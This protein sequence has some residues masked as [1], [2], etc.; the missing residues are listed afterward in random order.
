[1]YKLSKK[2]L[3]KLDG[4]DGDLVRVV[5]RAIQITEVDFS[6]LEGLRTKDRQKELFESGASRTM[7]SRHIIGEAVDLGAYISGGISWDWKYYEQIAKAMK[8]AADELGVIITWGG[9]WATFR[10][11]VHFQV[12]H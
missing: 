7:Q 5:K 1:M 4:V 11:G 12:E 10:D 9:D 8:D 2:S 3:S 6:V